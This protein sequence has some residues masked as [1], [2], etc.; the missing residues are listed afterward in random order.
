MALQ[1]NYSDE[2]TKANRRSCLMLFGGCGITILGIL[3]LLAIPVVLGVTTV[4]NIIG[5]ITG[6]FSPPLPIATVDEGPSIVTMIRPLGQL[7]TTR[8]E[9]ASADIKASVKAGVLDASSY[10]AFHVA[11]GSVEAG[12][13]MMPVGDED[14]TYDEETDTYTITLPAAQLTGCHIDF[15]RQYD[16]SATVLNVDWDALRILAEYHALGQFRRDALES[17]PSILDEAE[18][19][20]SLILGNFLEVLTGSKVKIDFRKEDSKLPSSCVPRA[21]EGWVYDEAENQWTKP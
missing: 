5:S 20:A 15:I 18:D 10:S 17:E 1:Q 14:I 9:F 21:P 3:L 7:V 16:K 4:G 6:I 12:I 11:E 13:D 2:E 8:V 19:R